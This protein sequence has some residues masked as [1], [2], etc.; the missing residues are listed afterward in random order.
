MRDIFCLHGTYGPD[1]SP[2]GCTFVRLLQPLSHPSLAGRVR[3]RHGPVLPPDADGTVVVERAWHEGTTVAEVEALLGELARRGLP[4]VHTF[5]D[6][7]LD[8][9]GD[10]PWKPDPAPEMRRVVRLLARE[11]RGL[12]VSTPRLRDRMA[13]INPRIEVVPNALDERLFFP[14]GAFPSPRPPGEATVTVGYMGTLTHEA[15]LLS[16]L[17]P[18]RAALRARPGRVRFELVGGSA[19]PGLDRLFSGLPFRRLSPGGDHPYPRFVAWMRRTLAWDVVIAPL[20]PSSFALAKSDLK[21]LDYSALGAAG[22]YSAVLPYTGT[23]RE[24]ETGLLATTEEEFGEALESLLSDAEKRERIASA[25]TADVL[26]HRTLSTR[27]TDWADA[28]DRIN[29]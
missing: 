20:V 8:L 6:D 4:L 17:A 3:L 2:Y 26:A 18:L 10:E 12:V 21:Y 28:L 27:A 1:S 22:V 29:A 15:D 24:G 19:R 13:R 23:V 25:A 5:D 16:V 14:G 9:N 11:A 7:L